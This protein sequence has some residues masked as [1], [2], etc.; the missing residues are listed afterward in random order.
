MPEGNGHWSESFDGEGVNADNRES[1]VTANSKYATVEAAVVGGFNAQKIAGKPFKCPESMDKL[2]D[3][4]ARTDFTTQARG[5]LGISIPKDVEAMKDVDFKTGLADGA[6][7]NEGFVS[8]VKNWAVEK[9]IP[10]SHVQ[11]MAVFYNGPL[12]KYAQEAFAAKQE[13]D[14]LAA[15]EKCNEGLIAHFKG[16]GKVK[17]LTALLHRTIINKMGLSAEESAEVADEMADSILTKNLVMA[18]GIL[19]LLAD[20]STEGTTLGGDGIR[21]DGVPKSKSPYEVKKT[22]WPKSPDQWGDPSDKWENET[23]GS[24]QLLQPKAEKV[25]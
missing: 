9:G 1:F 21:G 3:D 15:A 25:A 5:L 18:K 23:I 10:M 20:H 17:D 12:T 19:T 11:E 6:P 2:P 4:A 7:V 14:K 13:T 22:R 24:R 8:M 16:E